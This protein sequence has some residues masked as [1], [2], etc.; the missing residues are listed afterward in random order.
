MHAA[1]ITGTMTLL[2]IAD[3]FPET[4]PVFVDLGFPQMA[5]P[6]RRAALGAKVTLDQAARAKG[7]DAAAMLAD[8]RA[9]VRDARRG[10]DLTLAA[11]DESRMFPDAGDVKVAGLLPCPVRIPLLETFDAAAQAV[12]AKHGVSVGYRLAAASV[13][14]D[15]VQAEMARLKTEADLPDVFL[16]AGFEAFFD[17]RNL[18]RFKDAGVFADRSWERTNPA[19]DGLGIKD[20]DGHFSMIGAVPAIFLVDTQQLEEGEPVPRTWTDL[21]DPRLE[22][23]VALPV[24]DFDLFNGILL[25]LW[26]HYGDDGVRALA[27]N[28]MRS[29]HPSQAAG[30]FKA[31]KGEVPTVSVIPYFFSRMAKLNP[32][33]EIVWPEDGAVL[34]PIFMLE[35]AGAGEAARELADVFLSREAGEILAHKGLFPSLHPDVVNE[36][37]DPAPW[38]WLGWDFVREHDLGVMIPRMLEIFHQGTE[39][40]A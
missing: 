34:S 16:S 1:D 10:E 24:G 20:P 35:R 31:T 2:A 17:H 25:T 14:M 28:L 5:D 40:Q 7:R 37:P 19:F 33:V 8:L 27:R 3:A 13:G 38:L 36:L 9:A 32:K 39:A 29:L 18:R 6:A 23:R 26:K 21:L 12:E 30:R 4:I 11:A 22:R 15:V